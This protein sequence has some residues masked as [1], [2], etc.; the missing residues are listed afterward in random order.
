[1]LNGSARPYDDLLHQTNEA[2]AWQSVLPGEIWTGYS[3]TFTSPGGSLVGGIVASPG[4]G[5]VAA[6]L[7]PGAIL[8]ITFPEG[9]GTSGCS[10]TL[11]VE[12]YPGSAEASLP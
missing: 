3:G 12:G 8:R 9:A 4:Q 2:P 10:I 6:Q 11:T 5:A 7:Q 1:V